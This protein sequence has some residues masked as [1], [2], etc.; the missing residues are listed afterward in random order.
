VYSEGPNTFAASP[1]SPAPRLLCNGCAR[2]WQCTEQGLFFVPAGSKTPVPIDE[3]RLPDGPST[4]LLMSPDHDLANAQKSADG[5]LAFH[6]ITGPTG[7]QILAARYRPGASTPPG[8]W[9]PVTDGS[10]MDRNAAWNDR[11]DTLYFLSERCGFRCIW[12]QRLDAATK[13]P[14]GEPVAVRH[15]HSARQG[16]SAIGDVGAIGLSFAGGSLY[17]AQAEQS[18]DAWLARPVSHQSQVSKQ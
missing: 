18:G 11:S 17:F 10:Q 2:V 4:P 15:F 5:W 8:E 1:S 9:I 13:K 12:A 3:F 16:L 14:L 7:R 6:V